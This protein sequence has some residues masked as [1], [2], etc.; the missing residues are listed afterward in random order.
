M[1]RVIPML[2]WLVRPLCI[3]LGVAGCFTGTAPR[4]SSGPAAGPVHRLPAPPPGCRPLV[5]RPMPRPSM[6]HAWVPET[7]QTNILVAADRMIVFQTEAGVPERGEMFDPAKNA[8]IP[9]AT[10]NAPRYA[11]TKDGPGPMSG[12]RYFAFDDYVVVTWFDGNHHKRFSGA[13]LDARANE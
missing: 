7:I 11:S 13:V 5:V 9:I 4:A 10:A 12:Q 1:A 3:A 8:W 2:M 6:V